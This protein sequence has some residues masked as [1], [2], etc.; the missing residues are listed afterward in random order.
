MGSGRA[1]GAVDSIWLD[2]DRATNLMVIDSIMWLDGPVDWER[3]TA[4]IRHRLVDRYPVFHQRPVNASTP[5]GVP[6]WE[7]DP[8]FS[9]GRHLR[10]VVLPAPGD[11]RHLQLYVESQMHRPL[12]RQHPL[13]QVHVLD[14]HVRG[15]VV[16]TRFHHA[17]ADGIALAQVLLS[18]TDAD[19]KGDAAEPEPEP[20]PARQVQRPATVLAV[21]S[22]VTESATCA[23]RGALHLLSQL[24]RTLTPAFAGDA[25]ALAVQTGHIA[26]KLLL[27]ANPDTPL[28]GAPGVLKRAVWSRPR[29][30]SDIKRV[31][32]LAGATVNDVLIA[33][34]SGAITAYLV[35]HGGDPTDLTTMVPVSLRPLGRPL[36]RELGNQ[37]ALVML[38]L[39]TGLS[40]PLQRLSEA[41]LR[42]DSIKRSP[43]AVLTFGL[44]SAI[45]RASPDIARLAIDFFA[46]KTIGVTTNVAGP[47]VGRYVAGSRIAGVLAWV[48]SSGR[49]T[50]GVCIFSYDGKVRVGFKVDAGVV[51]DPARLVRA[52]EHEMDVLQRMAAAA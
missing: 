15:S 33:A 41:K 46:A 35:D 37:F 26:D 4:V 21:A 22:S 34:L 7:D 42:M 6:H 9:L 16:L 30:V 40:A 18:L 19:P 14:G 39:P 36:P 44:L 10:R 17:L 1:I 2:M 24:P 52:F 47:S 50:V 43:E 20:E 25:L 23:L 27:G 31:G 12:D 5:L 8:D 3:L 32:R 28:S 38:P 13:W 29:P 11:D 49:Q 51:P 48:P 45:G